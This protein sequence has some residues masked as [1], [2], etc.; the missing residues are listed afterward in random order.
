MLAVSTF[1]SQQHKRF[2]NSSNMQSP[3][4][5]DWTLVTCSITQNQLKVTNYTLL[6]TLILLLLL[7]LLLFI[8]SRRRQKADA[9]RPW[10]RAWVHRRRWLSA[11]W[12]KTSTPISSQPRS[13]RTPI[14]SS[15]VSIGRSHKVSSRLAS[16]LTKSLRRLFVTGDKKSRRQSASL[17]R[18]SIACYAE[19]CISYDRFCPTV[20]PSVCHTLVSC[21]NDSS[22]DHAV[23]TEG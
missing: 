2:S 10:E 22:Y 12:R 17:Q 16:K 8:R 4:T 9:D 19:R 23:F 18:V 3:E 21:Q 1:N 13:T 15:H 14:N 5:P 11:E 6:C 7:L 20:W